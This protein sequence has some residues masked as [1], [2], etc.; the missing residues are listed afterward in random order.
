MRKQ[1]KISRLTVNHSINYQHC[2]KLFFDK[3]IKRRYLNKSTTKLSSWNR[4]DQIT[5]IN[6]SDQ[7][8]LVLA[9][10]L[11]DSVTLMVANDTPKP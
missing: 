1:E 2:K 7:I 3:L 5:E 8:L 4:K 11:E 10:E 6:S 9:Q